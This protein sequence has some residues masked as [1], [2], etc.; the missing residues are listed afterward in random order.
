VEPAGTGAPV[1]RRPELTLLDGLRAVPPGV[2]RRHRVIP[3]R[4][5]ADRLV[6]GAIDPDS[7]AAVDALRRL[8]HTRVDLEPLSPERYR[9]VVDKWY[10]PIGDVAEFVA[11][12]PSRLDAAEPSL[13]TDDQSDEAPAPRFLALT[14]RAALSEGASDVHF[15]P[16]LVSPRV[17]YRVDGVLVD[18]IAPP[19]WLAERVIGRIK[20]MAGLAL[21]ECLFAQDGQLSFPTPAGSVSIRVS[22]VPSDKGECAV[23]RLLTVED[24]I[25]SLAKLGMPP[26]VRRQLV[27]AA[28]GQ[29]GLIVFAGPT[30]SGKTTSLHSLLET[31][32]ADRR[33]IVSIEEPV[34][35]RSRRVRQVPVRR[36]TGL[37]FA[38]A[39]RFVLRQDPDVILV[40]ETRDAETAELVLQASL[41]GH[42]VLTT[43]HATN[44][45]GIFDRFAQ[46]GADRRLLAQV[47]RL[48]VSQRLLRLLCPHCAGKACFTCDGTG[49]KGRTGVFEL[50]A[51]DD[52]LADLVRAGAHPSRLRAA[53]R[54]AG[55]QTLREAASELARTGVTTTAEIERVLDFDG[56]RRGGGGGP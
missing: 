8:G 14:L 38:R 12:L 10:G 54:A 31:V 48:A 26:G 33:N 2:A 42:L 49:L 41:A 7:L 56:D 25:P 29:E 30:G 9:E 20:A 50:V 47:T 34:E 27:E 39:L 32:D 4:Y 35:I 16:D 23:L 45:L 11:R 15:E 40:G 18:R 44:A 24:D 46:L 5:E 28:A 55:M 51:V 36:D 6:V 13:R 19:P 17:R 37:D 3:L 53:A 22:I 52:E 43:V 1:K 21:G